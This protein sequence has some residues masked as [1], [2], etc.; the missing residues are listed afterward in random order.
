DDGMQ[1]R[2][3]ARDVEV[4]VMDGNDLFGKGHCIP[5]GFLR[6]PLW[7]LERADVIVV[8]N[9]VDERH[10]ND[11][12]KALH[13][14]TVAPIIGVTPRHA[15]VYALDGERIEDIK[16]KKVG[17]FCGIAKPEYFRRQVE[18]QGADVV[19]ELFVTDHVAIDIKAIIRFAEECKNKG[20]DLVLCTEKDSVKMPKS[21]P[22]PLQIA[23]MRIELD[24]VAGKEEWQHSIENIAKKIV[25]RQQCRETTKES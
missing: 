15:G 19:D 12:Y 4:V 18:L 10:Y 13:R 23:L 1:Y 25:A 17:I 7:G 22:S 14:Y 16:G 3:L 8:N 6:E 11:A 5:R 2:R 9:I 20:C 21:I 24:V